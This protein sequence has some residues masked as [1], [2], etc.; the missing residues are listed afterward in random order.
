MH[1]PCTETVSKLDGVAPALLNE[2]RIYWVPTY[3][4]W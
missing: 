1:N 3:A 4:R 2:V